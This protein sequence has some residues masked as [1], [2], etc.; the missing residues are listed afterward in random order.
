MRIDYEKRL[1]RLLLLPSSLLW[2]FCQLTT[3]AQSIREQIIDN[4]ITGASLSGASVLVTAP[5]INGSRHGFVM[6]PLLAC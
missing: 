4:A 3:T 6:R 5:T 2:V 1:L